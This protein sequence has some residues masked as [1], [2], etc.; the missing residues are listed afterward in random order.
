LTIIVGTYALS[1]FPVV[2][3]TKEA[4]IHGN[5]ICYRFDDRNRLGIH[6]PTVAR[7][8][9]AAYQPVGKSAG[10]FAIQAVALEFNPRSVAVV[11]EHGAITGRA[12]GICSK[13]G[14][15]FP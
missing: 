2:I 3:A 7:I 14:N 6:Y 8:R 1:A 12:I 13:I 10:G 15:L 9:Q 11:A 5:L 4:S